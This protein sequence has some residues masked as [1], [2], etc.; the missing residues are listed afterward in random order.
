MV[1]RIRLFFSNKDLT[2]LFFLLILILLATFVELIGIASIPVSLGL[3]INPQKIIEY[4]P[5]H[6]KDLIDFTNFEENIVINFSIVLIFIFAL[7]NLFLF[8]VNFLQA[9][10]FRDLR[11]KNT[12]RLLNYFF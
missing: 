11:V 5:D 3:I 8:I 9:K 6:F 4:L 7:K 12:D 10:F 1:Q 2:Y